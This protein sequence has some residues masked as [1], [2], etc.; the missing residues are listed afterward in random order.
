MDTATKVGLNELKTATKK[1]AHKAAEAFIANKIANKIVKPKS[2]S[3][4]I[5]RNDEEVI[6]PP[7]QREVL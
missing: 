1:V 2:V 3:G 7:G 6:I 5:S 4:E